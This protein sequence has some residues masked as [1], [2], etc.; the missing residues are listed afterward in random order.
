[1]H[2]RFDKLRLMKRPTVVAQRNYQK[3]RA[4][5]QAREQL[6][7]KFAYIFDTNL[8][9]AEQSQSGLGSSLDATKR[10]RV[11]VETV[12]R[13]YKIEKLLDVPCGDASWIHHAKLPIR[14]YLG[15]DIVP[16][17]IEQN[18]SRDDLQHLDYSVNFEVIDLTRD[19]LTDAD[20]IL[21]RDCLVHLSFANIES[22]LRNII[23]SGATYLLTTTFPDHD[24]NQDIEDGDW[25]LLNLELP[26]FSFSKPLAIFNEGCDEEGGAFADKS[27]GLW[28]IAN[29]QQ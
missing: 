9:G 6:T 17:I 10:V 29:L 12:C 25:R 5:M 24:H 4:E 7:D 19:S 28:A 20:L 16:A 3:A 22:A 1:M 11:A 21:C 14:E 18:R 26:P 8:W 23:K 2:G 13:E 15:G 27:L